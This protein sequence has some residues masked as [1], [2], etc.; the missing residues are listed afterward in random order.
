[1]IGLVVVTLALISG[2]LVGLVAGYFGGWVDALI[3]R[4][5]DI[6]LAFPSL[7]LALVLVAIIGPG[8]FNAMLAIAVVLQPHF[9]RLTRGAVMAEKNR[10]YVDL[11]QG[12]R[13][14]HL[15]LMF[16]T[17]LPNCLGAAD[18][19]GDARASRTPSSTPP[20][21]ASSAWARSRRPRNG[22]PCSPRRASSS[23]APGGW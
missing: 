15:R 4:V 21:S 11:G 6:I 7:L 8:L 1:M 18:R 10:E 12:R 5:M 14:G 9:A 22:A 2:I 17:I 13:A 16:V 23:P 3:M 20:R 19:A